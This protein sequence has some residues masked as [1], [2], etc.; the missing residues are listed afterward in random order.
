MTLESIGRR[1]FLEALALGTVAACSSRTSRGED[2]GDKD[3]AINLGPDSGLAAYPARW[4]KEAG[5]KRV[6]CELCPRQCRVADRERGTCGVRENRDGKYYTLV[7]SR[8][9]TSHV[10]PIE[11]KPFY[12]V[13]PGKTAFSLAAP[14]CNMECKFCQNWEIAQV[15]P[16]QVHTV[17][18]RPNDIA[19]LARDHG[20]PAIAC[21]YSEPTV[22]SEYVYDIAVAAKAAGLRSL[23][24]SNGFIQSKPMTDL[25]DVLSAVKI[26]LKAFTDR[27]YQDQCRGELRPVLDT[28]RLLSKRKTWLEIVVL[29]ILG[30][31][32]DEQEIRSLSRFVRDEVGPDVPL[33]FTRFRPSYRMMNVPSTP[34]RTLEHAREVA[35]AEGLHFV[36]VGNIV[37]HPGN[38]TY[39]P[40]CKATI[41]R[42]SGL[43]LLENRLKAGKCPDC[44]RAI[45]G[46]WV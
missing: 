29:V 18:A 11:K 7:H 20:S 27:F 17:S 14:G 6:E 39:C 10:D 33:H 13:L 5:E 41:V 12:H 1:G 4:W 21:T 45:P 3:G 16:E 23:M 25:T 36:Y 15:R 26:D 42:R 8:P 34:V 43:S 24:I 22:W 2:H 30:L 35:L 46:I 19:R 28:L 40:G 31:N 9:C 32:D 37:G 44:G 38:H